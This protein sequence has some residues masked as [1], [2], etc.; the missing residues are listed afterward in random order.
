MNPFPLNRRLALITLAVGLPLGLVAC[1]GGATNDGVFVSTMLVSP[2]AY[3][4]TATITVNGTAL[5]KGI[6]V[7]ADSGCGAVTET[8]GGDNTSRRYSCKITALGNHTFRTVNSA[9]RELARVQIQVPEPEVTF[10][11]S[12][13]T[14]PEGTTA[15]TIT[16]LLDPVR[17]PLS[18][19]NFLA[20]VNAG[21]YRNVIFHRVVKDFVIQAGGFTAGPT[22][23]AATNPAIKLESQN[24]LSNLKYTLAM[25]RTNV[26]DSGTSQFYINTVDNLSLDYKSDADPGYAVFGKVISGQNIVDLVNAV[27]VRVDAGTGL[28]HLPQTNVVI[29][30]AVQTK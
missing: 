3:S 15:S 23:K 13:L 21:F 30:S 2:A 19:D 6:T 4:R 14:L 5:D 26:A 25:A 10:T 18:V 20:Y 7:S 12:G 22:V 28:T 16:V 11:L 1:G 27:P 8:A 24:G 29:T 17:A 9:G